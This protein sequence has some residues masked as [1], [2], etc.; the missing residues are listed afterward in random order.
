MGSSVSAESPRE[1]DRYPPFT[2]PPPGDSLMGALCAGR[3]GGSPCWHLYA[4]LPVPRLWWTGEAGKRTPPPRVLPRQALVALQAG[5]DEAFEQAGRDQAR[6]GA[7][8]VLN[9]MGTAAMRDLAGVAQ[10][11]V[12]ERWRVDQRSVRRAAARG[13]KLWTQIGAWPWWGAVRWFGVEP[14]EALPR[15]WW[16]NELAA[17]ALMKW[18]SRSSYL[19]LSDGRTVSFREL[20]DSLQT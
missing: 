4:D 18:R 9:A 10:S 2:G 16:E 6:G 12:A 20:G 13:R 14:G 8:D 15:D 3:D 19:A 17:L 5:T 7:R 1:K 11:A